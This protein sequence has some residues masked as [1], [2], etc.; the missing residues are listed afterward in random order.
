MNK[1]IYITKLLKFAIIVL[2]LTAC[3]IIEAEEKPTPK[4]EPAP[5]N[6]PAVANRYLDFY[7]SGQL[8]FSIDP[9]SITIPP[10]SDAEVRY[11]LKAVS[12]LGAINLSY[13][14]IRCSNRQK[15][16]YAIGRSDGNWS[17]TRSPEWTAIYV[18]GLNIQHATLANG[19]FCSGGSVAGNV[20]KIISRIESKKALNDPAK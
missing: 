5:L 16:I 18:Q 19:Y 10:G 14:G 15:I 8:D 6:L 7:S 20:A 3:F 11:T 1:K 2:G 4:L 9:D 17:L 12:K 13:E